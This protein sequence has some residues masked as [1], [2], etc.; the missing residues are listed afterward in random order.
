MISGVSSLVMLSSCLTFTPVFAAEVEDN[1]KESKIE[2]I[3]VIGEKAR[4]S[5]KDTTSSVSVISAESLQTMQ[6]QTITGAVSEIA[7]VVALSGALPDIRGV[8]GNGSAGG[9]NSV[10]GGAKGRVSILVDGVAEPFVADLTGDSGIWDIEQ[11][12]VYRGP[13]STSNG[14]NSIG[15]S[16]YIK[17]A[18]PD[19]DWDGAVR[20]GYRN[21]ESYKDVSVMLNAPIVEDKLAFRI[22]A[23]HLDG[24]T[25]T[26]SEEYPTNPA[27]YDLN[28]L[29]TDRVKAKLLWVLS[30]DVKA[31]FTHSTNH[32]RG[33]SGRIYYSGDDPFAYNRIFFRDIDTDSATTSMKVDYQISNGLSMDVLVAYMDYQWGFESYE[34]TEAAEQQLQIDET[35]I[36]L[37]AKVN[38][39]LDSNVLNGFIGFAY[40]EREQDILSTGVYPY[41]GDD[42]SD[43]TAL[44]GE[45][46]YALT[47]ELN[48]I[49][50]GRIERE[51]QLRNFT[52]APVNAVLDQSKTI[53]LPKVALQYAISAETTLAI[54]ARQG[55]NAP[56]GA[57]NFAAQEYYFYDQ[58]S[59]NTFEFSARSNLADG[60]VNLN[61]NLFY[62]DYD[63]YQA[64][65]SSR[66]IV[67]M[68]KVVT[69]GAELEA[70]ARPT[71]SV[72][73]KAGLGLLHTEIKDAGIDYASATGNELNSAPKI[74]A[75]LSLKYWMNNALNF[76]ASVNFVDEYY[77]DINNTEERV[78]G[79]YALVR[80]N[81]NYEA[82]QW[83][84]TA[85]INNALD[86]KGI[87]SIEPAGRR[88][89]VGYASVVDPR[90]VGVSVSYS[91]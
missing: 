26:N 80:F 71:T 83:L 22:S 59:V 38:F 74:T 16:I 4:R 62:N 29:K 42:G 84:V 8:T 55:Y 3:I 31:L 56:G 85:F 73:L 68:D 78:A 51:T 2:T 66:F 47:D 41:F 11:I 6:H 9:F 87:V 48:I 60:N 69:Y 35:S 91:F 28:G 39:G 81:A 40:F 75:N 72:E 23:Q 30:D 7:N 15:G 19:F 54:S 53:F 25:I 77:G 21:Q 1:E 13:Q 27:D 49:V 36:T 82:E 79:G 33:D 76:G 17:T 12:E 57:L 5:L 58:E 90:N 18:D 63:G 10:S 24:E 89:P 20:L 37:D 44:Y 70:V 64:L 32:E 34:P 88:Y 86:E 46:D 61:A 65:S 43:S 67:N 14:R 50:G 52:Y 45:L